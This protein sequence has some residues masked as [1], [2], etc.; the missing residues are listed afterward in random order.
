MTGVGCIV[1]CAPVFKL[2][3]NGGDNGVLDKLELLFI[4]FSVVATC[5]GIKEIR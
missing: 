1:S 5:A 2:G 4:L 3:D